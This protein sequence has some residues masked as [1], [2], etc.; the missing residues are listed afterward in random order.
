MELTEATVKKISD[1]LTIYTQCRQSYIKNIA[2]FFS[3][4]R[5]SDFHKIRAGIKHIQDR[6]NIFELIAGRYDEKFHSRIIAWILKDLANVQHGFEQKPIRIFINLLNRINC[7]IDIAPDAFDD[8][9]INCER[10]H[11][12][13]LIETQSECIIIENKIRWAADQPR[14]LARY[15]EEMQKAKKHVRAVVYLTPDGHQPGAD[16]LSDRKECIEPILVNLPVYD[17]LG[18]N[19]NNIVSG[20]IKPILSESINDIDV[21]SFLR[22]YKLF[23]EREGANYMRNTA[24][25]E[26]VEKILRDS[27]GKINAT[28]INAL[29]N[30][31]ELVSPYMD[32]L[33]APTILE[34]IRH[35]MPQ[36]NVKLFRVREMTE[37]IYIHLNS[38]EGIQI[39]L[40]IWGR[41]HGRR[42]TIELYMHNEN[43]TTAQERGAMSPDDTHGIEKMQEILSEAKINEFVTGSGDGANRLYYG[44]YNGLEYVN[45]EKEFYDIVCSIVDRLHK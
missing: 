43:I 31:Y 7:N 6:F 27:N 38:K 11:I 28:Q 41:E 4:K 35:R 25:K 45:Q 10:S 37:G 1:I 12:D 15:Y 26:F 5:L 19:G 42:Q 18:D 8:A 33:F 3:E 22:Q 9:E 40:D 17:I 20:L 16:S 29:I 23:L 39:V 30:T 14:Q 44:G 36:I 13:I 34:V 32:N 24:M 21:L 2:D